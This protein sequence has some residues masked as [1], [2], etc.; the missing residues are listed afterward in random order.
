MNVAASPAE[1]EPADGVHFELEESA[2]RRLNRLSYS[3]AKVVLRSLA[4]YVENRRNPKPET[5]EQRFGT[6]FHAELLEPGRAASMIVVL[7]QN[8]PRR[9]TSVQLAAAKPSPATVEAIAWWRD[10]DASSAGRLVIDANEAHRLEGML[11]AVRAHSGATHLLAAGRPEVS[12]LWQDRQYDVPCKCRIDF[13]RDDGGHVDIKTAAD[14]SPEAFA[15]AAAS[16][17]YHMQAAAYF[18]GAEHALNASPPFWAWVVVEKE[19][20]YGVATYVAQADALL[21]GARMWDTALARYRMAL[22]TSEWPAYA[23][24]I[25]P[26]HFPTWALRARNL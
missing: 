18:S 21:A 8:A 22:D 24:T 2:Y 23:P 15:R 1:V 9:P 19:P 26:L 17:S 3:G 16:F 20:P 12:V 10:F 7:P 6:V 13:L 11:E 4:H 25:E 14:A 5:D